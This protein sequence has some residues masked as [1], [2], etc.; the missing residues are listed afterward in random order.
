MGCV[1]AD[2]VKW[3][4]GGTMGVQRVWVLVPDVRCMVGWESTCEG[5]G[6]AR[7]DGGT[8]GHGGGLGGWG[9]RV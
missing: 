4:G 3:L 2:G 5:D 8:H 7:E 9:W 1:G 6:R